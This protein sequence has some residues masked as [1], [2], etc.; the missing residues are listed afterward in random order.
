MSRPMLATCACVIL[1]GGFVGG[2]ALSTQYQRNGR[3]WARLTHEERFYFMVGYD[4]GYAEANYLSDII[5]SKS[6]TPSQIA[7]SKE[8]HRLLSGKGEGRHTR[9]EIV[10]AVDTFYNDF[11]NQSVCWTVAVPCHVH[12]RRTADRRRTKCSS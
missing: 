8:M 6:G 1:L 5:A 3:G 10:D 11:R 2:W 7:L 12:I 9:K 4:I